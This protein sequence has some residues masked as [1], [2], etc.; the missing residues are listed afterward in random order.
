MPLVYIVARMTAVATLG[1]KVAM[2]T[3]SANI[4]S[5]QYKYF[6]SVPDISGEGEELSG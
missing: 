1:P 4:P 2:A 3:A 5:L 6:P